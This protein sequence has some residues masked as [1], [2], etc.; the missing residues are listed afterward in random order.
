MK[1]QIYINSQWYHQELSTTAQTPLVFNSFITDFH[2]S[3][4]VV[5]H[6]VSNITKITAEIDLF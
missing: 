6:L 2:T 3:L 4:K 5:S 1:L